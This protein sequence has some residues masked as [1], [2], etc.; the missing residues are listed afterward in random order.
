MIVVL[1]LAT[2]VVLCWISYLAG[3]MHEIRK[4]LKLFRQGGEP[5]A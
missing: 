4:T 3:S 2:V 1:A 5:D